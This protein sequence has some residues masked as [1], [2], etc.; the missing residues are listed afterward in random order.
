MNPMLSS[1]SEAMDVIRADRALTVVRAPD[2][3]DPAALA[4]AVAG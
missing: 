1:S 3:P 4:E 2:I